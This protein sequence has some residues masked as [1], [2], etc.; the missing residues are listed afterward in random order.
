MKGWP[1]GGFQALQHVTVKGTSACGTGVALRG[2]PHD[3]R[4]RPVSTLLAQTICSRRRTPVTR[5][6]RR[7]PRSVSTSCCHAVAVAPVPLHEAARAAEEAALSVSSPL[8]CFCCIRASVCVRGQR[9]GARRVD[10]LER[11]NIHASVWVDPKLEVD[12]GPLA[13]FLLTEDYR[14]RTSSR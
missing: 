8:A 11:E 13:S 7:L 14:V 3:H 4:P 1:T 10:S 6:P 12:C 2:A 9:V 5:V